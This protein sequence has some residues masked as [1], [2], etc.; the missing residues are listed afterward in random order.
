MGIQDKDHS[1][2]EFLS[3][4]RAYQLTSTQGFRTFVKVSDSAWPFY[5]PFQHFLLR[6]G[7]DCAQRMVI[8]PHALTLEEENRILGLNFR[9]EY[10]T[11][12]NDDYAGLLRRL[13]ITNVRSE[14]RELEMLDGLPLI[15]PFGVD[16]LNLKFMRRLV[17]AFV[18]VVNLEDRVP[19]FRSKVRQEDRPEVLRVEQ[20]NF[21][22][23]FVERD[24]RLERVQPV[25][26]PQ[27]VFGAIQDMRYPV[28]FAE[29]TPYAVDGQ[30]IQENILPC[31]MGTI[32]V[33][34]EAGGSIE[35]TS[36][37]GHAESREHAEAIAQRA[38]SR[39]Y[40]VGK[41]AENARVIDEITQMSF[42]S[43]SDR[44]F[45]GYCRCNFLDNV[46]RGGL[47]ITLEGTEARIPM[48]VYSRKHGDL[49]RDYNEFSLLPSYYSQGNGNFRDVNQNRRSDLFIN[50]DLKD[51]NVRHFFNLIQADGFNPLVV[52]PTTF[53]LKQA[54][55]AR[56]VLEKQLDREH[57]EKVLEVLAGDFTPGDL[58]KVCLVDGRM[59]KAEAS[60]LV[61]DVLAVCEASEETEHMHGYWSDHWLYNLDLLENYLAV[62]PE[63]ARGVLFERRDY[64]FHDSAYR[65]V[66]R[67]DKYVLW[68]GRPMQLGAVVKDEA[69]ET[70][71]RRRAEE[72]DK[73]RTGGGRGEVYRTTLFVKLFTLVLNKLASLDAHGVGV[74]MESD[75]PNWYDALNGLP[76]QHGSSLNETLEVKRH[77]LYLLDR[78]EA[79]CG[80]DEKVTLP[81]EV[82]EFYRAVEQVLSAK[83]RDR[84][85][86]TD[87]AMWDRITTAK[88]RY[89][90]RVFMGIDGAEEA[91]EMAAVKSFFALGLERLDDAV[92]K[93]W[94]VEEDLPHSY[95]LNEVAEY[96][97][98]AGK[99][100]AKGQPCY[101]VK[102]FCQK[103]LPLF[104]ESPVHFLKAERD[105]EKRRR[106]AAQ[107]KRSG[108]FDEKLRMYKVNE[109]L[110]Q[111]PLEIGRTRIF[112]PGWFENESIWLHMEYKYMLELLRNGLYEEFFSD[113][114]QVMV[115]FFKPEVY[116]RSILENSSFIASS[117][118]GNESVHGAGFVARLS[119]ATAEFIHILQLMTSGEQPYAVSENGELMLAFAPVLPGW[120]FSTEPQ[121]HR[122]YLNGEQT[123]VDFEAGT[124][125]FMFMGRTLVTYCNSTRRDTFGSQG[126][127][128]VRITVFDAEHGRRE[129]NEPILTGAVAEAVR[130]RTIDRMEIELA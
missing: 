107:V 125:S 40:L 3:A 45:D 67:D 7:N 21:Y 71:I 78:I 103:P 128:P 59:E 38:A 58:L 64:T 23:G 81:C 27:H 124:F 50:P 1:V 95:F 101:R 86:L 62:Y 109:S 54:G 56:D 2:M 123:D 11:V 55:K 130:Q 16:N 17:E 4:N 18:E 19:Y 116:G 75:K 49:E 24:G 41:R 119:G 110:E 20:G 122:L 87:F 53:R 37:I 117:A 15:V 32:S 28:R 6:D 129:F 47:P 94:N 106:L 114:P 76:G 5:E 112:T 65:V 8:E 12:P 63:D 91:I 36:L 84:E 82:V 31:A 60:V 99:R 121:T 39:D 118:N 70:L 72:A 30:Q 113:M 77:L 46:L 35:Y 102:A 74:E 48:Y 13:T 22:M 89:R 90:A 126:V 25:V 96:E 73:L 14:Q 51:R 26:D 52:K 111:Q 43:S 57:V 83:Y 97:L 80:V 120:L 92:A 10:C 85:E 108:L 115:P 69:K 29:K 42:V 93:A 88:E 105:D 66:P 44:R 61:A 127:R 34:I 104:L 79:H 68:E 98:I 100:N 9:V 33:V